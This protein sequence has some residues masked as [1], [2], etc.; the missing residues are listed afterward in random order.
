MRE[1][2]LENNYFFLT[3]L[4]TRRET[5]AETQ[6][7]Q[8]ACSRFLQTT[9]IYKPFAIIFEPRKVEME[10]N[11]DV[12]ESNFIDTYYNLTLKSRSALHFFT[13]NCQNSSLLVL[14]DDDVFIRRTSVFQLIQGSNIL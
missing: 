7:F 13:E 8:V 6:K 11:L 10:K 5:E 3:G 4:K 9:V 2:G 12:I 1:I 14:L